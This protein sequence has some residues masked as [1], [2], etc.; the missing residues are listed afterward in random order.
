V[1]PAVVPAVVSAVFAAVVAA[2]VSAGALVAAVAVLVVADADVEAVFESDPH[3][4]T[5]LIST[6]TAMPYMPTGR[7]ALC[8]VIISSPS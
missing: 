1:V 8:D 2:V 4:A 3:A 7:R 5:V 6:S